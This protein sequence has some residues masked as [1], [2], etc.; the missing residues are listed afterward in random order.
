MNNQSLALGIIFGAVTT[1]SIAGY[2]FSPKQRENPCAV[3]AQAYERAH[4]QARYLDRG[5]SNGLTDSE[6]LA[7]DV[8]G[9]VSEALGVSCLITPEVDQ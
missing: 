4:S 8:A 9:A 6:S 3:V 7:I 2:A 5:S 1:L